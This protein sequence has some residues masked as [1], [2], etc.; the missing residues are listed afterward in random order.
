MQHRT[1]GGGADKHL[2]RFRHLT[3]EAAPARA[4]AT[5]AQHL[6]INLAPPPAQISTARRAHSLATTSHLQDS[7]SSAR[8]SRFARNSETSCRTR[9][10][11]SVLLSRWT[12]ARARR[13][14]TICARAP[15]ASLSR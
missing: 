14:A 2:F 1:C 3:G 4:N 12:S 15:S 8:R 7:M 5:N 10:R 9:S 6:A 13:A 11:L